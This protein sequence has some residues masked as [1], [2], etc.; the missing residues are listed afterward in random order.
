MG[1]LNLCSEKLLSN[2]SLISFL[3]VNDIKENK[4]N[5]FATS[6]DKV[7]NST[8]PMLIGENINKDIYVVPNKKFK[9]LIRVFFLFTSV[10]LNMRYKCLNPS[11]KGF[12]C[13]TLSYGV[14][15]NIVGI[16]VIL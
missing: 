6:K 4:N 13:G 15:L 16:S 14:F 8:F 1:F 2:K 9:K 7:E 5:K 3:N 12:K 10:W 11:L